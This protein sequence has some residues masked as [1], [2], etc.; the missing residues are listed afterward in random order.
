MIAAITNSGTGAVKWWEGRPTLQDL[1]A[2][3]REVS[4]RG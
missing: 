4:H 2:Y 1:I 3:D